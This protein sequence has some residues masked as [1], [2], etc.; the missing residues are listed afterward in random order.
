MSLFFDSDT[1][2]YFADFAEDVVYA[3][4]GKLPQDGVTIKGIFDND[5][6]NVTIFDGQIEATGPQVTVKSSDVKGV[7]NGDTMT[8]R[9]KTWYARGTKDDGTGINIVTLSED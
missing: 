6:Q 9:N 5:S 2:S 7:R 3:A 1:D 4:A 8:I